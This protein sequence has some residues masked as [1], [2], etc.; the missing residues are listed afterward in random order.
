MPRTLA[1]IAASLV[2]AGIAAAPA[3]AG[4]RSWGGPPAGS[5]V[6]VAVKASGGGAPD[7]NPYDYDLLVQAVTATGLAPVLDDESKR[8]TV[9]APNDRAFTRLVADLTGST[10]ASE[11]A[12]LATA[13]S[14]L[15]LPAIK[16]VLLYHVVAGRRLG[17]LQVLL[18]RSLTMA[19]GGIVEPRGIVLRDESPALRDPRLVL[20]ALNIPATNGVIH[21]ID[22]VLVPKAG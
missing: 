5:I 3:A 11:Q 17:P 12:A 8:F 7:A 4:Q 9:F 20:F 13:V 21:T 2:I 14:A 6:D 1:A 10:P 15:G 19:N 18:S 22:R 16:N